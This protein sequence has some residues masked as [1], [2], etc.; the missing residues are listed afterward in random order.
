MNNKLLTEDYIKDL[1]VLFNFDLKNKI[2]S[3]GDK[4]CVELQNGLKVMIQ[5]KNF[6]KKKEYI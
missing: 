6:I 3:N 4:I 2:K 5:V 1:L